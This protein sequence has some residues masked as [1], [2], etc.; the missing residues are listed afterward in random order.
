MYKKVISIALC[1]LSSVCAMQNNTRDLE[2]ILEAFTKA[3]LNKA[4]TFDK[5][6]LDKK[7]KQSPIKYINEKGNLSE[8]LHGKKYAPDIF[9][10]IEDALSEAK[11]YTEHDHLASCAVDMFSVEN[12]LPYIIDNEKEVRQLKATYTETREDIQKIHD[13]LKR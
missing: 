13:N 9:D 4:W 1:T 2:K 3:E 10:A 6:E 11:R 7:L 5:T 8:K 12:T